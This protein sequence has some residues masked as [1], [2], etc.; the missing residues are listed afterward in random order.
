VSRRAQHEG[1]S[2]RCR[3]KDEYAALE[4]WS[5]APDPNN[6]ERVLYCHEPCGFSGNTTRANLQTLCERHV[7]ERHGSR[8]D[9]WTSG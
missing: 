5:I 8:P 2:R 1:E 7:R 6:P 9:M 3:P 4:G